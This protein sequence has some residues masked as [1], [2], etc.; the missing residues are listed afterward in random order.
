[1]PNR[2]PAARDRVETSLVK[3]ED[4]RMMA[5]TSTPPTVGV[6]LP[7][8]VQLEV[9]AARDLTTS[10]RCQ[11]EPGSG[12]AGSVSIRL[13]HSRQVGEV[14]AGELGNIGTASFS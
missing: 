5:W 12:S 2:I 10:Q 8:D 1:M 7:G 14:E 3:R 9:G 4:H 6:G 11:W 13:S